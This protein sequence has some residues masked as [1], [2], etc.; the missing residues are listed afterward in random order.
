MET[1]D[2]GL[3]FTGTH[4]LITGGAGY[5]GSAVV[6]AFPQLSAS[7]SVL[8]LSPQKLKIEHERLQIFQTDISSEE[9]LADAFEKA[10]A[11]F[12]VPTVCIALAA[13][14]LSV[15]PHHDSLTEM[16]LE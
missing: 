11:A 3:D 1:L 7:V 12:G 5:I 14:D 15:L 2:L 4:V 6:S 9:A 10:S 8:D 13:L 16:P